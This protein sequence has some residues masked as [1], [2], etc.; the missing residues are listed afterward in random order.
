MLYKNIIL[1]FSI[2]IK[3]LLYITIRL[4]KTRYYVYALFCMSNKILEYSHQKSYGWP[5][6]EILESAKIYKLDTSCTFEYT[7]KKSKD[8]EDY[9][10]MVEDNGTLTI[11]INGD[12]IT[13]NCPL[14]YLKQEYFLILKEYIK[15]QINFQK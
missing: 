12:T 6:S 9:T 3:R 8:Y 11:K 1:S 2:I 4:I 5:F 14:S 10:N 7:P 15:N 13:K